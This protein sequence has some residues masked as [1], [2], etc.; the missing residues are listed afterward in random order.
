MPRILAL[1]FPR[2]AAER[3]LRRR[4]HSDAPA[5]TSAEQKGALR[6]I[7]LNASA[8]AEGLGRGMSLTDA[9]ALMPTLENLPHAPQLDAQALG[10]LIRWARGY[11]PIVARGESEL[12]QALLT[13]DSAGCA[14]LFG[15][16]EAMLGQMV[17]LLERGGY[18][19][20]AS[21]ADTPGAALAA[22]LCL[23]GT[24]LPKGGTRDALSP[25]P[26]RALQLDEKAQEGFARLGLTSIGDIAR[27]PRAALARRFGM[28]TLR[29]IDRALGAEPDPLTPEPPE[30]VHAV[31]L[32]LPEPIAKTED[33]MA[34]LERLSVRL[35]QRLAYER[36]GARRLRLTIL[37][38]E[39]TSQSAEIGLA[40]PSA[41][42]ARFLPLFEKPVEGLEARF[43]IDAVRLEAVQTEA[44]TARQ[45]T[46]PTTRAETGQGQDAPLA[47]LLGILGN[48][49]GFERVQRF[50]PAESH[51]PERAF[52][53]ASA[54]FC[55]PQP[56]AASGLRRPL[57]LLQN[58]EPLSIEEPGRPPKR[59]RWR[60]KHWPVT[61]TEGPE[62][63]APEWWWD[64]PTWR[65]G[66]RDYWRVE[67]VDGERLWLC[68][69]LGGEMQGGWFVAGRF[70]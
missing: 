60:G 12:G 17:A 66:T 44:M 1:F 32:T 18:S 21:I 55:E 5:A 67:A 62:R 52:I 26:I 69:A 9:R 8:E 37:R 45:E 48:R 4:G 39:H 29:I 61:R 31:R 16:E 43:G 46:L 27:L 11:S 23:P 65:S 13:L 57:T 54:A 53:R 22:A 30:P 59:F 20:R 40:Q 14:H 7:A 35:C 70:E 47:D 68:Q 41:D 15:G 49:I 58:L 19:A 63:I 3:A 56:F 42:P 50:L 51:I 6:L 38:T 24:I 33:V 36:K 25:L 2:F 64:D 34:A 10:A 28:Q